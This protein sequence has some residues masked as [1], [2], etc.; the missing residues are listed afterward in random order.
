MAKKAM[1][2]ENQ[3][4]VDFTDSFTGQSFQNEITTAL[5]HYLPE[6]PTHSNDCTSVS[7][8]FPSSLVEEDHDIRSMSQLCKEQHKD[9]GISP[10]FQNVVSETDLAQ[11]PIWFYIENGI[12]MRKWLSPEISAD[13][14]CAVN[15][16]IVVPKIYR[17]EIF[18]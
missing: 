14:E 8:H 10:L 11:D 4:D 5:S 7:D 18:S 15:H 17:S 9:P 1:L 3:S 6:H 16:Q 2:T 12:L 13:D